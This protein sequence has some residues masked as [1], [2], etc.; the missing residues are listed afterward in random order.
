MSMQRRRHNGFTILEMMISMGLLIIVVTMGIALELAAAKSFTRNTAQV[1]ISTTS[2]LSLRKVT[3][4]LR[5]GIDASIG[6]DG[7]TMTYTLPAVSTT[8]D[9]TTGEKEYVVPIAADGIAHTLYVTGGKLYQ[10]DGNGTAVVLVEDIAD[11]DPDPQSSEYGRQYAV[12][13]SSSIGSRRA[14]TLTLI[15]KKSSPDGYRYTRIRGTVLLGNH[16]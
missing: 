16:G 9:P 3:N 8:N 11:T 2:A 6:T 1:D 7:R 14:V 5:N 12:F 15:L 10:R 13:A 4:V